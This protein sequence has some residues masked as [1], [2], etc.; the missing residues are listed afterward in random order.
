MVF[1]H[2]RLFGRGL[3]VHNQ[4]WGCSSYYSRHFLQVVVC[5]HLQAQGLGNAVINH[6]LY[7]LQSPISLTHLHTHA[8]T[9]IHA[10]T[11]YTQNTHTLTAELRTHKSR[12]V[13]HPGLL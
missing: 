9:R 1:E 3:S 4:L 5:Q 6:K 13:S 11:L 10:H 8:H 7:K 12:G 2:R